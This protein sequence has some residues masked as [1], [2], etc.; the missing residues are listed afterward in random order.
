VTNR[1]YIRQYDLRALMAHGATCTCPSCNPPQGG[2]GGVTLLADA[3]F[4]N[5]FRRIPAPMEDDFLK[6]L[7]GGKWKANALDAPL[8]REYYSRFRQFA[9]AGYGKRLTGP[10]DWL[11]FDLMERLKRSASTFS[12]G[13]LATLTEELKTLRKLPLN[14]FLKEGKRAVRRHHR[15]YLEAELQTTLASANSAAKWR[16]IEKRAYLYPNLRYETAGDERV[17]ESHRALDG[18]IYPVQSTFWDTFMPP[19]GWRCR[20]IVIQTD[21]APTGSEALD[22][23]PPKGF[24][25]NPGRT[26]KLVEEDHPYYNFDKPGLAAIEKGSEALRAEWETREVYQLAEKF[27]GTTQKLPGMSKAARVNLDFISR[28]LSASAVER[29]IRNDILTVLHL[30]GAQATL[31]PLEEGTYLYSIVVGGYTF[32]L[33]VSNNLFQIIR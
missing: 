26:G 14:D 24:R 16:D 28:T 3:N 1:Q 23:E 2:A 32:T 8:W 19:N 18:R 11:E 5:R 31:L 30:L 22:F 9:E 4:D 25:N 21:E 7:H 10:A 27:V 13:K 33:E 29:A 15:D 12:G 6:R 17:R 20:C